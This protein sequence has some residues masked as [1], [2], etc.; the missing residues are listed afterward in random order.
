MPFCEEL[1]ELIALYRPLRGAVAE[2]ETFFVTEK[3][4]PL[5]GKLVYDVVCNAL[6]GVTSVAPCLCVGNAQPWRGNQQRERI[7]GT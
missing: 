4:A 3:G 7:V 6:S 1:G 5:Y 2:A